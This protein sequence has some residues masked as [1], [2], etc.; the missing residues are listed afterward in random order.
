MTRAAQR[1]LEMG[2]NPNPISM[3]SNSKYVPTRVELGDEYLM[4]RKRGSVFWIDYQGPDGSRI[5]KSSKRREEAGA[6]QF[7]EDFL[8]GR[9]QA[10]FGAHHDVSPHELTLEELFRRYVEHLVQRYQADGDIVRATVRK[11]AL[12]A[13]TACA[14]WGRELIAENVDQD[15]LST[16]RRRMAAG[17]DV[18]RRFEALLAEDPLP[19]GPLRVIRRCTERQKTVRDDLT[20]IRTAFNWAA[21]VKAR[22]HWLLNENPF[23]RLRIPGVSEPQYQPRTSAERASRVLEYS[24]QV[25]DTGRLRM[26]SLIIRYTGRRRTEV[27]QMTV[28]DVRFERSAV[29]DALEVAYQETLPAEVWTDGALFFPAERNKQRLDWVVPLAPDVRAELEA[30]LRGLPDLV[31][32]LGGSRN[33]ALSAEAPLFPA[34]SD[35][36]RPVS[37]SWVTA[38]FRDAEAAARRAGFDVPSKK[39][40]VFHPW[41]RLFAS[42]RIHLG[43]EYVGAVAG[44][45]VGDRHAIVRYIGDARRVLKVACYRD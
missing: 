4:L 32:G 6:V 22:E 31:V 34:Q 28:G 38:R 18:P 36:A 16:Y 5:R 2:S 9:L 17:L 13:D 39:G 40:A 44:W 27:E 8:N 43:K 42:E 3:M 21:R 24:D 45:K 25:D 30:Y 35:P 29:E 19:S 7:A 1:V 15:A 14:V 33:D 20:M 37:N 11:A 10:R 23:N 12:V 26:L 41:R